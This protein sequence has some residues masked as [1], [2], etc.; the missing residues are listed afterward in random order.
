MKLSLR[1]KDRAAVTGRPL[2]CTHTD[3]GIFEALFLSERKG[4]VT[5]I[6]V[7]LA[8]SDGLVVRSVEL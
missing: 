4:R 5:G 1:V 6:V 2:H 7:L 8:E 3:T